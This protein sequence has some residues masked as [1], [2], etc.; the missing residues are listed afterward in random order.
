[1]IL[2]I[3]LALGLFGGF[4]LGVPFFIAWVAHEHSQASKYRHLLVLAAEQS[5]SSSGPSW[6]VTYRDKGKVKTITATGKDESE[7]MKS[8]VKQGIGYDKIISSVKQ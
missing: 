8:L 1:M 4:I 7:M 6:V 2:G 5:V 3:L